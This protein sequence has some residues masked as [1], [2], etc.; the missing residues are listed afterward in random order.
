[1]AKDSF[2]IY[3]KFGEQVKLLTDTQAGVLFK[4]LIDYQSGEELPKM[5][6]MTNIVFSVIRQQIDFENQKYQ[7]V[8]NINKANG[9]RGGRPSK[10]L[11]DKGNKPKK[12]SGF[13]EE[14]EKPSGYS[15]N[16]TKAK[17]PDTDT[18]KDTDNIPPFYSPL[19]GEKKEKTPADEFYEKYPRYAKDRNKM[20]ADVDYKRLLEEFEKSTYL[21]SL[22]TVKQIN[23]IY[24]CILT[25]DYRDKENKPSA[26]ADFDARAERERFYSLRRHR[27]IA[28]AEK[29]KATFMKDETFAKIERRLR[30][31]D[32]EQGKAE[33]R[34]DKAKASKLE[35]EKARLLLQKRG[36]IE[37][38]GMTEE[39]L[40]PKWMCRKC[41][42]TGFVEGIPCD[43]Y[44]G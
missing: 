29:I 1:M 38:N 32:C 4:A 40:E 17:K 39:D 14:E 33:A 8:C 36:I 34:G 25:G 5:D 23:E 43:C 7:E 27:A 12:P 41:Q 35:Q 19:N 11:T 22:Y 44:E 42:D 13:E 16:R 3:T 31:I 6:G 30:E 21:R 2:I 24:P 10:S 9:Q 26:V 18:D 37:R 15:R 20:R 28:E